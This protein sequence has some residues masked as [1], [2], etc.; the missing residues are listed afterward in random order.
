MENAGY[1]TFFSGSVAEVF[2]VSTQLVNLVLSFLLT[3]SG[4]LLQTK[5]PVI[6]FQCGYGS[7]PLITY[8]PKKHPWT[9]YCLGYSRCDSLAEE[10]SMNHPLTN[11]F[12]G[13]STYFFWLVFFSFAPRM[14]RR[15]PAW[16]FG[17][18][19]RASLSAHETWGTARGTV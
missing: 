18:P 6:F 2:M 9:N 15:S 7:K 14:Q 11:Y 19:P 4:F 8:Y 10:T 5:S 13:F 17:G 12:Y 16:T 1:I 3:H